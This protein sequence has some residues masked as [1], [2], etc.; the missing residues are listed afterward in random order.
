MMQ[1]VPWG[2]V[3]SSVTYTADTSHIPDKH[4][5][6]TPPLGKD[7]LFRHHENMD[8]RHTQTGFPYKG[9]LFV[10]RGN[11]VRSQMGE[12][13][14]RTMAPKD[15][16]VWSAGY[17]PIGVLSQT[18]AVMREIG[19]DISYHTSKSI[20][21]VPMEDIDLVITLCGGKDDICPHVPGDMKRLHWP[22]PDPFMAAPAGADGLEGFRVVR[23]AI[24]DRIELLLDGQ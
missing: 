15:V 21:D 7:L 8:R 9:V 14:M 17:S 13:L 1:F 16:F 22:M 20:K 18:I 12:G 5:S 4:F 19:I 10:C 24:K 23:D 3:T 2:L 11:A 6:N